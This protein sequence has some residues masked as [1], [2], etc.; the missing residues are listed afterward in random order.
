[1]RTLAAALMVTLA[2]AA[3]AER[4]PVFRPEDLEA[5]VAARRGER[6]HCANSLIAR[7]DEER[8]LCGDAPACATLRAAE[9]ADMTAVIERSGDVPEETRTR[10]VE[11]MARSGCPGITLLA[12]GQSTV[13]ERTR[14]TS[15]SDGATYEQFIAINPERENRV[16][17]PSAGPDRRDDILDDIQRRA[18]DLLGFNVTPRLRCGI[19]ER[20]ILDI[21]VT[22][23]GRIIHGTDDVAF[24]GCVW[25]SRGHD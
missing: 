13:V 5:F 1:M 21:H 8:R 9:R 15:P 20:E 12:A 25:S 7:I 19:S 11:A 2:A 4:P 10:T 3:H 24:A 16:E 17:R 6:L 23:D 14:W 18:E 22:R